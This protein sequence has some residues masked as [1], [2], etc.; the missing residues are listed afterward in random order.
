M[1]ETEVER[2]VKLNNRISLEKKG[3]PGNC[4]K[5]NGPYL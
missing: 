5:E 4:G 3:I 2:I 1:L